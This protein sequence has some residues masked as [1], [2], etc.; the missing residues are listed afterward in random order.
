MSDEAADQRG[1]LWLVRHGETEWSKSGQHTGR[2]DIDLTD[3]G[4]QNARAVAPRLASHD[5][6]RVLTSP[7]KRAVATAE[8]AAFGDRAEQLDDLMEWD[9][10]EEEGLTTAHIRKSRPGWTVWHEGPRGGETVWDVGVRADRVIATVRETAGSVLAF[11]HG[12]FARVL[13]ARWIGLSAVEGHKLKLS[14]AAISVLG[15]DREVA[16]I[17]RWNDTSHLD[18]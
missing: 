4:R 7:L 12:H 18:G 5:F 2:S 14:T 10:G 6:A 8:L 15:Y 17:V 3:V 13:G 16:A 1:Q 9:Y 11:S